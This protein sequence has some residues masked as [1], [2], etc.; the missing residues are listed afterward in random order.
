MAT[1]LC[2]GR[3]AREDVVK[4]IERSKSW[5]QR[6]IRPAILLERAHA[7]VQSHE[8]QHVGAFGDGMSGALRGR[9]TSTEGKAGFGIA[10]L[11]GVPLPILLIVYLISRC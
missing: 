9:M 8:H 7:H 3:A 1:A 5:R 2:T 6:T 11:L 10:W 4:A